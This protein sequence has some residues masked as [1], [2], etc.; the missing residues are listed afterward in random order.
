VKYS[1]TT[2]LLTQNIDDIT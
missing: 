1:E 2:H